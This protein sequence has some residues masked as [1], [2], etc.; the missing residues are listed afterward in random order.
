M[1]Q[2]RATRNGRRSHPSQPLNRADDRCC[3]PRRRE[4]RVWAEP[5]SSPACSEWSVPG[6]I[7]GVVSTLVLPP[8]VVPPL[9]AV[10][11]CD[12]VARRSMELPRYRATRRDF[13]VAA[14]L[15]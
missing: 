12:R 14:A 11:E 9:H 6:R 4:G 2:R 7:L 15:V 8:W 5:R 10:E 1:F 13:G 3:R